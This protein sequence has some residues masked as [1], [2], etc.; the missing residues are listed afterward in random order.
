[1]HLKPSEQEALLNRPL[2][3]WTMEDID[4]L[5]FK[6]LSML[7][8]KHLKTSLQGAWDGSRAMEIFSAMLFDGFTPEYKNLLGTG[9]TGIEVR[10]RFWKA[11]DLKLPSSYGTLWYYE[12][13]LSKRQN[14]SVFGQGVAKTA[15]AAL[16][17]RAKVAEHGIED[18][19]STLLK[20]WTY[21]K[22]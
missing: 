15:F 9:K 14:R 22:P 21:N 6:I 11:G 20:K 7:L 10:F 13:K 16:C 17:M 18:Q 4:L 19:E 12:N 5:G 8:E 2:Q 3:D 1:M